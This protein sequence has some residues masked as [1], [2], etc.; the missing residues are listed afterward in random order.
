MTKYLPVLI[1]VISTSIN[2][3]AQKFVSTKSDPVILSSAGGEGKSSTIMLAWTIGEPAVTTVSSSD[4][5][6]TQ[7]FH[8]P[9]VM[10]NSQNPV[11]VKEE[12][13]GLKINIA[14]NPVQSTLKLRI[15]SAAN[16]RVEIH[17]ST[18]DGKSLLHRIS[19]GTDVTTDINM[20]G[21]ISGLYLLRLYDA[22]GLIKTFEIVK[23]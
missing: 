11:I 1:I 5:I 10:V 3:F 14:P 15:V 20:A 23:N 21:Y 4:M 8:Q 22:F 13:K 19:N 7:G 17:L 16:A 18:L 6:L 9:V 2:G 12:I